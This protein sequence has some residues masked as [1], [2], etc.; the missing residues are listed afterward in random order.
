MAASKTA[1]QADELCVFGCGGVVVVVV[2]IVGSIESH[3][4]ESQSIHTGNNNKKPQKWGK[5]NKRKRAQIGSVDTKKSSTY[6]TT[7]HHIETTRLKIGR[8]GN[9]D[10]NHHNQSINNVCNGTWGENEK[11]DCQMQDS[12]Q[13][14]MIPAY[15]LERQR[16]FALPT[17]NSAS[18]WNYESV[19]FLH[20]VSFFSRRS[21]HG[22]ESSKGF[23]LHSIPIQSNPIHHMHQFGV[24]QTCTLSRSC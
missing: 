11:R 5:R 2:V 24:A 22:I 13:S 1:L 6:N 20:S 9:G 14:F 23:F 18:K 15:D 3:C 17:K 8:N 4:V 7:T 19:L 21:V 16:H 12:I 10:R